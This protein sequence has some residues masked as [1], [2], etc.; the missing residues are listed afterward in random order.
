MPGVP[1]VALMD[2]TLATAT[3][4]APPTMTCMLPSI[5]GPNTM[6]RC[7]LPTWIV[8]PV[9]NADAMP[10]AGATPSTSALGAGEAA[11]AGTLMLTPIALCP[12]P[13][14]MITGACTDVSPGAGLV[15]VTV[16][17]LLLEELPPPHPGRQRSAD[18]AS[19][20]GMRNQV[21]AGGHSVARREMDA[22]AANPC[23][24]CFDVDIWRD[25]YNR[26][27][28]SHSRPPA[29]SQKSS[30][31]VRARQAQPAVARRPRSVSRVGFRSD[32]AADAR[33]GGGRLL[34]ALPGKVPYG[35]APGAGA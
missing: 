4:L 14:E 17:A 18:K 16:G 13:S 15:E 5:P 24:T 28:A 21:M 19:I 20:A 34:S 25:I 26:A 12:G 10:L 33:G 8:A 11:G 31:L 7:V 9:L 27:D 35:A 22:E 2:W 1:S 3:S 29:V 30:A 6:T 23:C 32:A